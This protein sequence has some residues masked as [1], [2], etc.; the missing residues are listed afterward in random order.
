ML[1]VRSEDSPV[2]LVDLNELLNELLNGLGGRSARVA[3]DA[4][5]PA[6]DLSL[7]VGHCE[8]AAI[9]APSTS[10]HILWLDGWFL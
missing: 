1:W 8:L 6:L 2:A 9:E 10:D 7:L 4:D 5:S 3:D